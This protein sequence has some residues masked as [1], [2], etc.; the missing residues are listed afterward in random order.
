MTF[1]RLINFRSFHISLRLYHYK[2]PHLLNS[3]KINIYKDLT[4]VSRSCL[5]Q[6]KSTATP[7]PVGRWTLS[8]QLTDFFRYWTALLR[9]QP[10]SVFPNNC[11]SP[12]L[13]DCFHYSSCCCCCCYKTPLAAPHP[14]LLV[15]TTTNDSSGC[16][17]AL[18]LIPWT[19]SQPIRWPRPL[20]NARTVTERTV[21]SSRGSPRPAPTL[22][23]PD[24]SLPPCPRR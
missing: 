10:R 5:S 21:P 4:C 19:T 8:F 11:C 17:G 3:I 12:L 6:N 2:D 24:S 9:L 16:A 15:S 23:P 7:P 14:F 20:R 18:E 1:K 13:S 22:F